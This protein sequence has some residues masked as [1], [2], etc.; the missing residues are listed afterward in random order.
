MEETCLCA[1]VRIHFERVIVLPGDMQARRQPHDAGCAVGLALIAFSLVFCRIPRHGYLSG[2]GFIGDVAFEGRIW[3]DAD[4]SI[5]RMSI[6]R[7][8]YGA[9]R[10]TTEVASWRR[11]HAHVPVFSDD[12]RPVSRDVDRSRRFRG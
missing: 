3:P 11:E 10:A 12:R 2:L 7:H 1:V 5:G 6:A 8:R 4:G 9:P